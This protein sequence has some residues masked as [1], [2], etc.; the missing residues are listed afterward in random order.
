MGLGLWRWNFVNRPALSD[1][2]CQ[3]LSTVVVQDL[4]SQAPDAG[5]FVPRLSGYWQQ[6]DLTDAEWI[7]LC[8]WMAARGTI[9]TPEGWGW[10]AIILNS[11]PKG[12]ALTPKA[13]GLEMEAMRQPNISIGDGNGPINIGG[14]QVVISGYS[15]S[16]EDLKAL[17]DA[18]FQD[19]QG[20]SGPDAA[21]ANAAA[22]SL[23]GI[24]AGKVPGTSPEARGAFD[25]ILERA[26]EAVG[27]AG[28]AALWA[29]TQG[30]LRALGW[31]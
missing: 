15:L 2:D 6:A 17:A 30:V 28:G 11:P 19:A 12:L 10:L 4:F 13:M 24:L 26:S 14:Q 5:V 7:Y 22:R 8:R 31:L 1:E 29:A 3:A 21:A 9:T 16:S 27:N 23:E 18:V 20:M 25:W